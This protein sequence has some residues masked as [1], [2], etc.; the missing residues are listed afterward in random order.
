MQLGNEPLGRR[1]DLM[2]TQASPSAFAS[3]VAAVVK[4]LDMN[5]LAPA[6]VLGPG[7]TYAAEPSAAVPAAMAGNP[8]S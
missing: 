1:L 3:A 7:D 4:G 8:A 2:A 5:N 6:Y